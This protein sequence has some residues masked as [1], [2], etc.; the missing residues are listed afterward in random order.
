MQYVDTILLALQIFIAVG[1]VILVHE[2]GHFMMARYMGVR[3]DKFS[4]GFGPRLFGFKRGD[5]DY[6]VCLFF[7]FGGFVKMAG[8]DPENREKFEKWE[9]FGQPWWSRALIV[10][11]GPFMNFVFAYVVFVLLMSIAIKVPDYT[12]KI[13]GVEK[14]S[15]AE[16]AGL[17]YN[18]QVL[19]VNGKEV[20]NWSGLYNE[21]SKEKSASLKIITDGKKT[22]EETSSVLTVTDGKKSREVKFENSKDKTFGISPFV[23]P[24]IDSVSP[25]SPAYAAGLN[26][27][28]EIVKIDGTPVKQF[29]DIG[30]AT[31][32]SGG[33]EMLFEIKR[34]NTK[35]TIIRKVKPMK[36]A[37][38][39]NKYIIGISSKAPLF[40]YEKINFFKSL[41]L[42]G[43][44]VYSISK[45]QIVAI[46]KLVTGK[47]SAKES[48]G[49][50]VMIVQ[51]AANMAKKGMNDFIF[52]FAF[53]S[54]AL[55]LFNLIIPIPVVDCGV[56][57]MFIIEGI[58]GKPISYKV[59]NILAQSGFFLLIALA[60]V[61]TWNDIAKIITRNLI[62]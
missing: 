57:I 11:A 62:K 6:M 27:G 19:A 59:Q 15:I 54:V 41:G 38:V 1:V 23:L 33:K 52:F 21:I 16:K 13:G 17:K 26:E 2:L 3:V 8:E 50:P 35:E 40:T 51:S 60:V 56:L 12:T 4:L 39:T 24:V 28:D 18:D 34:G 48:L 43:E 31:I 14:G 32:A 53:I 46:S 58:R 30:K 20:T 22:K 47:M 9:Y 7:F 42:A 10:F 36:D 49:G 29:S 44:Q 45:L 61:I 5:T 37:I 25:G 55:G